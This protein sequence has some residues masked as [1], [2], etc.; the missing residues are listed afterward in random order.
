MRTIENL[1]LFLPGLAPVPRLV[2]FFFAPL[3]LAAALPTR[4]KR[5]HLLM[6]LHQLLLLLL[7]IVS[8]NSHAHRHLVRRGA[9]LLQLL[10]LELPALRLFLRLHHLE[11]RGRDGK[12]CAGD[13]GV[14]DEE[15][16]VGRHAG[17]SEAG[18]VG[19]NLLAGDP[20]LR[21]RVLLLVRGHA[22]LSESGRPRLDCHRVAA[23]R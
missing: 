21:V 9:H 23:V 13:R 7:P 19:Q 17:L 18:A 8:R 20:G 3:F 5:A 11:V 16:A 6:V 1:G 15:H 12:G 4:H 14:L 22:L 2:F 10:H